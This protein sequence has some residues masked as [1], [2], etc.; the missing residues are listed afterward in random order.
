[1]SSPFTS[2]RD[3]AAVLG[4]WSGSERL[5]IES[6]LVDARLEQQPTR[7]L[8]TALRAAARKIPGAWSGR[9]VRGSVVGRRAA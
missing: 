4:T 6:A 2:S 5:A 7:R 3:T 8:A 1:M 9:S